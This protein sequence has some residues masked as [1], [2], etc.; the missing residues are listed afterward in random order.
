M[1]SR[2]VI[3]A[4][5]R[6]GETSVISMPSRRLARSATYM[7][8]A[9]WRAVSAGSTRPAFHPRTQDF[10]HDTAAA[11]P[12]PAREDRA[13]GPRPHPRA[14]RARQAG[15]AGDRSMAGRE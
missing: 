8:S 3:D 4:V 14:H 5:A 6:P 11:D 7:A 9:H 1:S 15:R 12:R 10:T 13:G 2:T